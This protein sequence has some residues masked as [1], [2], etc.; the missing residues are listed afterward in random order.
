[1]MFSAM[2]RASE[3][4]T[5]P[6]RR[7]VKSPPRRSGKPVSSSS[8]PGSS[9]FLRRNL[10]CACEGGC[11]RCAKQNSNQSLDKSLDKSPDKSPDKRVT[12]DPQP[13]TGD[14]GNG[15]EINDLD[16][17]QPNIDVSA[18]KALIRM[19]H[20]GPEGERKAVE[21]LNYCRDGTLRGFVGDDL[22]LAAKHAAELGTVRWELEQDP[23]EEA[24]LAPGANGQPP[25]A[26]YRPAAR[27]ARYRM[28]RVAEVIYQKSHAYA[29]G[30]GR[31]PGQ[32]VPQITPANFEVYLGAL[33]PEVDGALLAATPDRNYDMLTVFAKTQFLGWAGWHRP[34]GGNLF[35]IQTLTADDT[36]MVQNTQTGGNP[37][38]KAC[39]HVTPESI[40]SSRYYGMTGFAPINT[41]RNSITENT[42]ATP[43]GRREIESLGLPTTD[44]RA[45]RNIPA[46]LFTWTGDEPHMDVSSSTT[47]RNRHFPA[48][49]VVILV[50]RQDFR[51]Y[52]AWEPARNGPVM[53]LAS[54]DWGF[55]FGISA[56]KNGPG[57]DQDS[58]NVNSNSITPPYAN[59]MVRNRP[60][61][62]TQIITGQEMQAR[63]LNSCEDM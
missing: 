38:R 33:R 19:R 63:F 31:P 5:E 27:S 49:S 42:T 61:T 16:F 7:R 1:M 45:D 9:R 35:F 8:F 58:W 30:R 29:G 3:S 40:D 41:P 18:Q 11:P 48:G 28:D 39:R 52:L 32:V 44:Q 15:N 62:A 13:G 56:V 57:D 20:S 47:C 50:T 2:R 25:L 46:S 37:C 6:L 26:V 55:H 51:M 24:D 21:V 22:G 53:P 14:V 59:P 10:A 23:N 17:I 12:Q 4:S 43:R 34:P 60:L 54:V 36:L